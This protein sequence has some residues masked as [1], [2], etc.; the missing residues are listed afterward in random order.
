MLRHLVVGTALLAAAALAPLPRSRRP[1]A[2]A[3]AWRRRRRRRTT[4]VAR[5]SPSPE[6][7]SGGARSSTTS[8]AAGSTGR[9]GSCRTRPHRLPDRLHLLPA[10][11]EQRR[12]RA[13][14]AP[15]DRLQG[16]AVPVRH[17]C[18]ARSRPATP[19]G[20]S[21]PRASSPQ[22]YG[23]F[24]VRAKFPTADTSGIHGGFWMYPVETS[25]ALA[26]V[27]RDR[28]RRVVV[29]PARAC[30]CRPS[31]TT[32]GTR[33]STRAG[34]ARSGPRPGS[35]ATPWCGPRSRCGSRSTTSSASR[36]AGRRTQPQVAPAAVRPPV[37]HDPQH[38]RRPEGRTSEG[39]RRDRVPGS[40]CG[41]LR[42]GV[43]MTADSSV[44]CL[45]RDV[46]GSGRGSKEQTG[47]EPWGEGRPA[48]AGLSSVRSSSLWRAW[49]RRRPRLRRPATATGGTGV[50][51]RAGGSRRR[52][53][54]VRP[55]DRQAER[56]HLALLVR[57]QL[58]PARRST[59][60]G[61][62]SSTPRR[63]A[64]RRG[65]PATRTRPT[66]SRCATAAWC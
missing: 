46:S 6:A 28:R 52:A 23:R 11:Q 9:S 24:E 49:P 37:Q 55:A 10:R 14:R 40:L 42:E 31:T 16:R 19:A 22:T 15:P 48:C 35:T 17:A 39:H 43:A 36:V 38:G 21:A 53:G 20:W 32:A 62:S 63:P 60:R 41:R 47:A 45:R 18:C 7:A 33:R 1:R 50:R 2:S 65:A 44:T 61:G 66:T 34:A 26:R 5:R 51:R 54:Q 8:A 58:R 13:R 30:R 27:R 64:S 12:R 4:P 29:V 25:T 57:R 59:G 3:A 56:P